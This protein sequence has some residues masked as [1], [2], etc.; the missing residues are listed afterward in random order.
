MNV[1]P[2][3]KDRTEKE[4]RRRSDANDPKSLCHLAVDPVDLENS[5]N[6]FLIL[7]LGSTYDDNRD[8]EVR[9]SGLK[10]KV[11]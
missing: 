1:K 4:A 11:R 9:V 6:M 2:R 8:E 3:V 10:G 5:E 7:I